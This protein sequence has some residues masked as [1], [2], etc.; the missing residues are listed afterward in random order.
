MTNTSLTKQ[1]LY[2]IYQSNLLMCE[3]QI[4]IIKK[5]INK[6]IG[7]YHW[8][9][10]HNP[11]NSRLHKLEKELQASQRLYMFLLGSWF[12][13]RLYKILYESSQV[14]FNETELGNIDQVETI[15]GKWKKSFEIA[16]GHISSTENWR[17][18]TKDYI[19]GMFA[20]EYFQE[21]QDV[22]TARNKLAHGESDIQL[23]K[24]RKNI[25]ILELLER[26]SN[27]QQSVEFYNKLKG[28]AE[29]LELLVIYKEKDTLNFEQRVDSIVKKINNAGSRVDNKDYRKYIERCVKSFKSE[30]NRC[31]ADQNI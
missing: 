4:D 28:I 19:S 5:T 30:R 2:E 3:V 27:M 21:I 16:I 24:S 15:A 13:L 25:K 9:K 23:T 8:N 17:G 12:E 11:K 22:I 7:E 10:K 20:N 29:F 26:V 6:I 31:R 18:I 14:S 1:Q